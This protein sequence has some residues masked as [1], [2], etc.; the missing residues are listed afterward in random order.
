MSVPDS[1]TGGCLCGGVRY[2]FNLAPVRNSQSGPIT[3]QCTQCR[4]TTGTLIYHFF[5]IHPSSLT[6]LSDSTLTS[7]SASPGC[8]RLFCSKCGSSIAWKDERIDD[9]IELAA[10][11]IDEEF[12]IGKRGEDGVARGGL[13]EVLAGLGGV[14]NYVENEIPGVTDFVTAGRGTRYA[15]TGHEEK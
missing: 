9:S 2:Q 12:L 1:I 8:H 14:H 4:K 7:Y 10:G 11:C 5:A 15:K 13:G 6:Y 3:C